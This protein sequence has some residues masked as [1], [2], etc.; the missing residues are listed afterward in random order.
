[1]KKMFT[2][3]NIKHFVST[4]GVATLSRRPCF[5][6]LSNHTTTLFNINNNSSCFVRE[7]STN[8]SGNYQ[9]EEGNNKNFYNSKTLALGLV[10]GLLSS[11]AAYYY[12]DNNR[13]NVDD[14]L[15]TLLAQA[16]SAQENSTF[17]EQERTKK[18]VNA[19][20][21]HNTPIYRVVL[22][23]GPCA[24]KSSAMTKLRER[25]QNLGF[26][27]FIIPEAATLLMTGGAKVTDNSSVEDVLA[28]ESS[29]IKTQMA[30]EDNFQEIARVSKKPTI[31]LCDRGTLDPKAYMADDLWQALMDMNGWSIP[32]LRDKRYD[33]VIHLVTTAIGAEKFYTLENNTV[34]TETIEQA[35]ELDHRLRASYI[36]HSQLYIVD[37][38][39]NSFDEKLQKV[40]NILS[41]QI[42][43]PRA[44][45]SRRRFLL[46]P[47]EKVD[48][49]LRHEVI[50]LEQ[51]FI[52]TGNEKDVTRI[53]KRGQNGVF[54]YSYHSTQTIEDGLEK[55]EA[56]PISART[57]VNLSSQAD[58]SRMPI[59][60][61]IYSFVYMNHY[62]ELNHYLNGKGKGTT[63]LTVEAVA[64][65]EVSIPP[66]LEPYILEEV[67]DNNKLSSYEYALKN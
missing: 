24:G 51:I 21:Q 64:G 66:F 28:F 16:L 29:L 67:T 38:A 15:H 50:D 32:M 14:N 63:I 12:F 53:V 11:I 22:T 44:K 30:I 40:Y 17:E 3:K 1:M 25:L 59:L 61:K 19:L 20:L 2:P 7:F 39:V 65:Q 18:N 23:G 46:K 4:T 6:A 9:Q 5:V 35:R 49:N 34:R 26:Q 47:M 36:G 62:F 42:G 10:G 45:S 33:C 13:N 60:K 8:S 52:P 27:V 55:I 37:N 57:Y 31:L 54:T 48:M 56:R 43:I 58:K 41:H